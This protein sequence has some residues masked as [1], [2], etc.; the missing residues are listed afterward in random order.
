MTPIMP[1]EVFDP[2]EDVE[3]DDQNKHPVLDDWDDP[4]SKQC[5]RCQKNGL[6]DKCYD[7]DRVVYRGREKVVASLC[8][9]QNGP[10]LPLAF[11]DY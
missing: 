7:S 5:T 9:V 3:F 10:A 4:V 11:W 6:I 2:D 8:C 1:H